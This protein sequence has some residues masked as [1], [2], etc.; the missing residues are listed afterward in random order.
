ML[1]EDAKRQAQAFAD[2]WKQSV[3]VIRSNGEM[4]VVLWLAWDDEILFRARPTKI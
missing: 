4:A 1:I 3:Y 2:E